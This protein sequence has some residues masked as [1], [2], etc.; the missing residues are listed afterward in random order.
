MSA[1]M[2]PNARAKAVKALQEKHATRKRER[3]TQGDL[4]EGMEQPQSKPPAPPE[5]KSSTLR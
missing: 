1:T 2:E 4:L 3:A 5:S